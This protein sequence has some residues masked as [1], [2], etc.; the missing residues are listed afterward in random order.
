MTWTPIVGRKFS[1]DEFDAYLRGLSFSAWRPK[2]IT[3]HNTSAPTRAQY[4]AWQKRNPPVTMERWLQN[5]VGY[6]RDQQHW[7]AGPHWFVADDG[8]GVFT[9]PTHP[10]VHTPSW[11][12]I[13]IGVET[14]G[15]YEAEPFD[16]AVRD[17]LV[18]SLASIHLVLGLDPAAYV[19][20]V[21]GLHFHKEDRR[22]THQSCPGRH[23]VKADLVRAVVAKMADAHQG[24]H[25]PE[26]A[27]LD[28]PPPIKP[29]PGRLTNIV[30]TEFGGTG[31]VNESAYGGMVHPDAFEVSLPARVP[32]DKRMVRL[33]H[34]DKF[35]VA[36]VNDVGPW[37]KRDDYWNADHG[38]P[39]AESQFHQKTRAQNGLVPS[40]PAAI[41]GT[42]AVHDALGVLGREGTRQTVVDW[43]F[44][45]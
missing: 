21:R 27:V 31:D 13:A 36:K 16:G 1:A 34:L 42:R 28:V 26:R 44:V 22:T 33:F 41:D 5:L 14:V 37:N 3:V 15:E 24:D 39:L 30:M 18:A 25:T 9:P 29:T 4:A 8:I 20:G 2:F 19:L 43:E 45:T 40:N 7:S 32:A 6:Y 35:V 12:S 11:N 17:N 38:R 23:M 10:G